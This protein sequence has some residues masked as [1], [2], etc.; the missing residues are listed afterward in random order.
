[1]AEIQ[2]AIAELPL[3]EKKGL[4][5]WLASQDEILGDLDG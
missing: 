5:A 3:R 2:Q 1:M 4:S